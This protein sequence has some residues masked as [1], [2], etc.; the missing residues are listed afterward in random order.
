M[1]QFPSHPPQSER[2]TSS[3]LAERIG[4]SLRTIRYW[5]A[6]GVTPRRFRKGRSLYYRRALV[7]EWLAASSLKPL[8]D[9]H[10]DA[11]QRSGK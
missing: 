2:L 6:A 5:E 8:D 7:E 1:Q 10:G 11:D 3:E 4:V 9:L